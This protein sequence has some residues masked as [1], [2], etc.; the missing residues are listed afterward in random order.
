MKL[1]AQQIAFWELFGYLVV[2]GM[3]NTEEMEIASK[4]F[5]EQGIESREGAE[6]EGI[7]REG[8]PL[9][10]RLVFRDMLADSR[11]YDPIEQLLGDNFV[12]LGG[13]GGA[14]FVGDT[15]WH[16]DVDDADLSQTRIKAN[17]YLDP[18]TRDSGC[19]RIVPGSH[20][21]PLHEDLK[22][23]RMGRLKK[24]IADGS[25]LSNIAPA[26]EA[27][28]K[29]LSDWELKTGVD[30]NNHGT[31]Y[32]IE[33]TTIPSDM[34]ET[35]PGDI[36]FFDKKVVHAAFGGKTGRR[37]VSMHWAS[38]PSEPHHLMGVKTSTDIKAGL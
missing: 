3:F 29:E 37:V 27:D 12:N 4:E 32:G 23:L 24:A 20:N 7:K 1:N 22:P 14:L 13:P 2:K 35:N 11:I 30:L 10:H 19:L 21:N 18:V 34:L 36:I 5:D 17:M 9:D 33:P 31:I 15:Q 8:F 26:S 38:Y 6:F 28:K 16:P 25:L